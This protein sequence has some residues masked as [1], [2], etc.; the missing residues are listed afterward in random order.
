MQIPESVEWLI[1]LLGWLVLF[2][3][4]HWEFT[5]TTWIL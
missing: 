4:V 2:P 1:W 3:P 5:C